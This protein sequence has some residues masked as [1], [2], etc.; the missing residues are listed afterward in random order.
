MIISDKYKCI[1]IRIPKTGST[2]IEELFKTLDPDCISSDQDEPLH[3]QKKCSELK[4]IVGEEKWNSYYKFAFIREPKSWFKSKYVYNLDFNH[5]DNE[6]IDLLLDNSSTVQYKHEN[7]SV[8]VTNSYKLR[9]PENKILILNDCILFYVL[10]K[11]FGR[12]N[13][14]NYIDL[15][16]DFLGTI[17][18]ID[19]DIKYI[20]NKIGIKQEIKL[21]HFNKS[22]S[23]KYSF[24]EDSNKFLDILLKNDIDLYERML[25]LRN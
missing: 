15:E 23:S 17:E 6:P 21:P 2:S 7:N 19:E 14:V 3:E 22:S 24:D 13:M 18:N 16:I 10:N 25:Y 5:I 9:D 20:F 12:S 1:F 4:N 11:W 8:Y